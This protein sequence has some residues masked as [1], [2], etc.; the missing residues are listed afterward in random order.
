M[1]GLFFISESIVKSTNL[2][3]LLFY[4]SSFFYF[5]LGDI[6]DTLGSFLCNEMSSIYIHA[7][8]DVSSRNKSFFSF[9]NLDNPPNRNK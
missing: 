9:V 6:N 7:L 4:I 2:A 1:I 5:L 8:F 3:S